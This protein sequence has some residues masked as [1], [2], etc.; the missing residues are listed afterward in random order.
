MN[1]ES[2]Q[3]S[4]DLRSDTVT[5]PTEDMRTAM[6]E[7]PLGDDVFGEDPTVNELERMSA[8]MLGKEAAVF[9]ASGT[10]GNIA[11]IL[12]HCGRG[13][14]AI[15]GDVSHIFLNEA[16][17]ISAL[18]GIHPRIVPTLD[19]GTIETDVIQ[20]AIRWDD[21]HFPITR[22]ICLENTHNRCGGAIL[23][24]EYVLKVAGI[25]RER[26]LNLHLDG[27]RIFNAAVGLKLP[28]A[29]LVEPFDSVTFCLSKGLSA[30]VGSMLCGSEEFIR[31]ARRARKILGGAMRQA[32]VIAAAGIVALESMVGRLAEDHANARILAAGLDG[33]NGIRVVKNPP[34]TNMVF[35]SLDEESEYSLGGLIDSLRE[36]GVL[37]GGGGPGRLR[38]VT[39]HGIAVE[40]VEATVQA[41]KDVLSR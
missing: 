22:L 26:Q 39:H 16:G 8:E 10:M 31:K 35:I 24:L 21:P 7:A 3:K 12:S 15:L 19:D 40:D 18:G 25:A 30:P 13:D 41:F 2:N 9:V 5:L 38:L 17:G 34:P 27:A 20:G 36:Q 11:A 33:I 23:G 32:G 29:D 37:V 4:I 1:P 6:Y 28:V 14:E